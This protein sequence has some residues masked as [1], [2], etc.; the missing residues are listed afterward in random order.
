MKNTSKGVSKPSRIPPTISRPSVVMPMY[1]YI[2]LTF[3]T[4][5]QSTYTASHSNATPT[6]IQCHC[7]SDSPDTENLKPEFQI[8]YYKNTVIS[9][10]VKLSAQWHVLNGVCTHSHAAVWWWRWCCVGLYGSGVKCDY[11]SSTMSTHSGPLLVSSA[12]ESADWI[13]LQSCEHTQTLC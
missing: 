4:S 12:V 11:R 7:E 6:E 2:Q 3:S 9:I 13:H 8:Q 10:L 1:G 5:T